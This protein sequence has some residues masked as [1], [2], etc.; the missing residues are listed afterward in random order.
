M[1]TLNS[2]IQYLIEAFERGLPFKLDPFQHKAMEALY[3]SPGGVLVFAPT[4]SGK[5][6]IA[7]FAIWLTMNDAFDGEIRTEP[8][9]KTGYKQVVYTTPIKALSNQKFR[10]FMNKY[11]EQSVGLVTGEHTIRD[12]APIVVMTTEILRNQIYEDIRRLDSISYV[13]LDEIHYID[14]FPRGS[15]WEEII[16]QAPLHIKL[17]GL[18]ATVENVNELAAWISTQRGKVEV[19]SHD[20][21]PVEL[22]LWFY[23]RGDLVPI[24]KNIT[25]ANRLAADL[26]AIMLTY[27]KSRGFKQGESLEKVITALDENQMLPSIIF[28]FSR[29]GC[30]EALYK[31]Y[32]SGLNLNSKKEAKQVKEYVE[33][34]LDNMR[35]PEERLLY[36]NSLNVELLT[37]GFGVH[38]AGLLP[39]AK[40]IV[41]QLLALGLLKVVFA[42]E[43]LALGINVPAKSVVL[44]AFSKYDGEGFNPLTKGDFLQ[45]TGRAGRRGIDQ[46]GHGVIMLDP[47]VD[48]DEMLEIIT[49]GKF[50]VVSKF[51]PTYNMVLNLLKTKD[52]SD[53]VAL[54]SRSLAQYQKNAALRNY[55]RQIASWEKQLYD[56]NSR[57]GDRLGESTLKMLNDYELL[58]KTQQKLR[59]RIKREQKQI[60]MLKRKGI[61]NK[62]MN[63]LL[64]SLLYQEQELE[65]QI[66]T[67]DANNVN[68]FADLLATYRRIRK[69]ENK[70]SASRQRIRTEQNEYGRTFYRLMSL[71]EVK[72]FL[73]GSQVT[74]KGEF[75]SHIYCENSVLIADAVWNGYFSDISVAEL[76]AAL[77]FLIS[78]D[79]YG[80]GY[81]PLRGPLSRMQPLFD[82]L[83]ELFAE[84]ASLEKSY[85]LKQVFPPSSTWVD[86][87]YK[88]LNGQ[89]FDKL[90]LPWD[91][92][93]GDALRLMRSLYSL[94]RQL[95]QALPLDN[96]LRPI[97]RECKDVLVSDLVLRL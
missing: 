51:E 90:E 61:S 75:A 16:I 14:E 11:G 22:R 50:E 18:S 29:K 3:S 25:K 28:L 38:H 72:G 77:T 52:P 27:R 97:I 55:E 54:L 74:P 4:S 62:S 13:I 56:L 83:Y 64:V 37:K 34:Q 1:L 2:R 85:R 47:A 24:T 6:V 71:L 78:E 21:R 17:V 96:G 69:L 80:N 68:D 46:L 20:K 88:Y 15:V 39:F 48:L 81:L 7:E 89:S 12:D 44:S 65:N 53:A 63:E 40:E 35:N 31:C 73:D 93:Y 84:Y 45:L 43:T 33:Q 49:K 82:S 91:Y 9:P 70:I 36:L 60:R 26:H 59:Q 67:H 86:F 41:E 66:A 5:T 57:Y 19:I 76:G 23:D 8:M 32:M 30:E 95:E 92:G 58:L 79:R 10:D 42:T 87:V 94:L